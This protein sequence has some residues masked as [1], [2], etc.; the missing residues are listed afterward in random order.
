M[1]INHYRRCLYSFIPIFHSQ[2][3]IRS[4]K[5]EMYTET[6]NKKSLS[7][8]DDKRVI[9]GDMIS[10]MAVGHFRLQTM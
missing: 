10:T 5:H 8:D 2:K 6:I 9:L 1:T 7:A 4:H 3:V